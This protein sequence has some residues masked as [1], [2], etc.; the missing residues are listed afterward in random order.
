MKAR[1]TLYTSL[2][3]PHF[4]Y[5]DIIWGNCGA[6]NRNKLQLAQNYAPKSMLGMSKF[7]SATQALKKLE[8][9]PLAEKRNINIAVHVKKALAGTSPVNINQLYVNQLSKENSR[10]A[11]R[12]DLNYPNHKLQQY[13]EGPLYSSIKTWN[14]IPAELRANDLTSFKRKLQ[15]FKT[16]QYLEL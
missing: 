1:R 3:T 11:A 15:M 4:S 13:Q 12:G 7:S 8:L 5:G 10:A 14:S 6:A 16:K 2:V 9:L